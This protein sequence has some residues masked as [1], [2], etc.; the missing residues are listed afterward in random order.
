MKPPAM[1]TAQRS[2]P[3][4]PHGNGSAIAL[5]PSPCG[6]VLN[7]YIHIIYY[8]SYVKLNAIQVRV[9]PLS[10]VRIS[11]F[12]QVSTMGYRMVSVQ[13]RPLSDLR[14]VKVLCNLRKA[15]AN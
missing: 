15:K 12:P 5:S 3:S 6:V 14:F 10:V 13:G 2:K 1:Y 7:M 8:K 9:V 11:V 4:Y